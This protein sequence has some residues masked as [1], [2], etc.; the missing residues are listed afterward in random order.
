MTHVIIKKKKKTLHINDYVS[1]NIQNCSDYANTLREKSIQMIYLDPPFNS[2]RNYTMSVDSSIGFHDKWDNKTYEEFLDNTITKLKPLLKEDGT[3]FLH[4][5]AACM[6]I[7]HMVLSK[8]FPF[9]SPI[10]WKNA[11]QKTM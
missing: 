6:L 5:S 1:L 4:I 8:H 9:V 11:D 3:L 10:F 7:P 2:D